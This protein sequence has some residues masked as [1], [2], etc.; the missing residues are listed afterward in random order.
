LAGGTCHDEFT[1]R[2]HESA[3][4]AEKTSNEAAAHAF[5]RLARGA[6][7]AGHEMPETN[8]AGNFRLLVSGISWPTCRRPQA[9]TRRK[10][11]PAAFLCVLSVS[12]CSARDRLLRAL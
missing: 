6:S 10:A 7:Q 4:R 9:G 1:Q 8:S 3:K 11:P 12:A 5:R 2:A